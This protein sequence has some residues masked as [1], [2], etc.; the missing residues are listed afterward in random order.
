MR[1]LALLLFLFFVFTN[2]FSQTNHPILKSSHWYVSWGYTKAVYT[3]SDIH[4]QNLSGSES[5]HQGNFYD[6][7]LI[8]A[9]AHDRPDM[10]K[11]N[12]FS[13]IS[14]PQFVCRAGY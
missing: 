13:N 9:K 2:S 12:D 6:F 3:K 14:I 8:K 10:S 4:M 1:S 7:T 5:E 11:L